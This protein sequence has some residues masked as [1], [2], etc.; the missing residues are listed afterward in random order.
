[1]VPN[2]SPDADTYLRAHFDAFDAL[3]MSGTAWEYSVAAEMWN[4]EDFSLVRAD[5]TENAIAAAIIRPFPRAVAG[6]DIAFSFDAA[7]R[8]TALSYTPAPGV[9]EVS[10]PARAYPA[11]F[12]VEIEGG[13]Y[14]KADPT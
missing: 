13:C 3:G 9:T 5:G 2:P 14:D 10:I 6:S 1:G 12:D 4:S 8:A 11:G 7:S